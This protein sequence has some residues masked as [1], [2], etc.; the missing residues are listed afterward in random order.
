MTLTRFASAVTQAGILTMRRV[1]IPACGPEVRC[2]GD[3]GSSLDMP[4]AD[5]NRDPKNSQTATSSC[6]LG[7][8]PLVPL[9]RAWLP[10]P[11]VPRGC[12]NVVLSSTGLDQ[13]ERNTVSFVA[14]CGRAF[15]AAPRRMNETRFECRY[16]IQHLSRLSHSSRARNSQ[17][18]RFSKVISATMPLLNTPF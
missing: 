13:P 8:A 14:D 7:A 5:T 2:F 9:D 4:L 6:T 12:H 3:F 17:S 15:M 10:T 18:L 11:P 16:M 1:K